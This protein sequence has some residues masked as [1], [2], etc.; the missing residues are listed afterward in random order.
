[1]RRS[2]GESGNRAHRLNTTYANQ[3]KHNERTH[4]APPHPFKENEGT[5]KEIQARPKDTH[6]GIATF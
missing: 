5:T 3:A 1:M 6:A 2:K 4:P